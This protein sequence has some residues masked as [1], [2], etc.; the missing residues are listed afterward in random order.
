[1]EANPT[2]ADTP[3]SASGAPPGSAESAELAA[4]QFIRRCAENL[5]ALRSFQAEL[6]SAFGELSPALLHA[7]LR[8]YLHHRALDLVEEVLQNHSLPCTWTI[9]RR[10]CQSLCRSLKRPTSG[11]LFTPKL[12]ASLKTCRVA[13]TQET[14][15]G[16]HG[17]P[18]I[19]VEADSAVSSKDAPLGKKAP[20]KGSRLAKACRTAGEVVRHCSSDR[21]GNGIRGVVKKKRRRL[22]A[23]PLSVRCSQVV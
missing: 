16:I 13:R 11:P 9:I 14:L 17:K 10:S 18:V 20:R 5:P 12:G 8:C 6:V 23:V 1:M 2:P 19:P 15:P 21:S 3:A 4:L 7:F 22:A